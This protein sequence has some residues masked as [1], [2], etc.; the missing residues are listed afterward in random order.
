MGCLFEMVPMHHSI[1]E[2]CFGLGD[3]NY[4]FNCNLGKNTIKMKLFDNHTEMLR[5][6]KKNIIDTLVKEKK[7]KYTRKSRKSKY[8]RKSKKI[9]CK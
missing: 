7:S 3:F 6:I 8:A 1:E 9:T 2:A 5:F 4:F